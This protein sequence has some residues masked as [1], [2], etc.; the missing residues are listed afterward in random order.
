MKVEFITQVFLWNGW[1]DNSSNTQITEQGRQVSLES[2][3]LFLP[4]TVSGFDDLGVLVKI[5]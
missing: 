2:F 5:Q 4:G 3:Y 1:L